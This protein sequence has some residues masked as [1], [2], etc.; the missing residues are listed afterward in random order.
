VNMNMGKG[1]K[2]RLF[3]W[4]YF[5]IAGGFFLLD[6]RA[7]LTGE[8]M[9]LIILRLAISAGFLALGWGTWKS[10]NERSQ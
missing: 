2:A 8:R 5:A 9:F 1:L 3:A 4:W 10:R 6:V 7:W